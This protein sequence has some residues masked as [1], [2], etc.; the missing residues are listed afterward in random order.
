MEE[1]GS[2]LT[3]MHDERGASGGFFTITGGED[4][5]NTLIH[6]LLHLEVERKVIETG[7][8]ANYV[9]SVFKLGVHPAGLFDIMKASG[10][11]MVGYSASGIGELP[12]TRSGW[13]KNY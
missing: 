1:A 9:T 6:S 8:E 2:V 11:N 10:Y 13:A 12:V 4:A 5:V 7:L 3:V